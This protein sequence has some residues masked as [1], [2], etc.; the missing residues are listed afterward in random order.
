MT[1]NPW[2]HPIGADLAE[3]DKP[4]PAVVI[5]APE[6]GAA[7]PL[8]GDGFGNIAWEFTKFS[9]AVL[10]RLRAWQL[11]FDANF[12]WEHGWSSEKVRDEWADEGRRLET[13]VRT[14]LNGRAEVVLGLP[15]VED[16]D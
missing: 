15:G 3:W 14:E 6:Y 1:E 11:Q 10:D 16:Q 13:L 7:L 8:W 2:W 4:L 9:P 5:L 12:H